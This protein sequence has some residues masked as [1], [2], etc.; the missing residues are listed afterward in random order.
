MIPP[1][2]GTFTEEASIVTKG[3]KKAMNKKSLAL[4]VEWSTPTWYSWWRYQNGKIV[5]QSMTE[6]TI[7]SIHRNAK[8][9]QVRLYASHS[10][11]LIYP[12][13]GMPMAVN[14]DAVVI[15]KKRGRW[16][17]LYIGEE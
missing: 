12:L 5:R 4:G 3:E 6:I 16:G 2:G 8:T 14:S 11:V 15:L 9:G 1:T 10:Q 17:R 13:D 7:D